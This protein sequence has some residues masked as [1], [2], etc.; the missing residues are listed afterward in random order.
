MNTYFDLYVK[1]NFIIIHFCKF[2]NFIIFDRRRTLRCWRG[3]H[4]CHNSHWFIQLLIILCLINTIE[5]TYIIILFTLLFLS[6]PC[7]WYKRIFILILYLFFPS[8]YKMTTHTIRQ[9][10]W[11][12]A[13]VIRIK[14]VVTHLLVIFALFHC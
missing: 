3:N 9:S 12:Y 13:L 2:C 4:S 8:S 7:P 11:K 5:R 6:Y 14:L 1:L 10:T